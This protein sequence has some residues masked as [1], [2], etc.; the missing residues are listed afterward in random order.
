MIDRDDGGLEVVPG[1]HRMELFRPEEAD[2]E[3]SFAREYVPPPPGPTAVPVDMAP[4]DIGHHAGRSTRGI[5]GYYRTLS[6]S[7]GSVPLRESEGAAP[8][9]T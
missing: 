3:L 4:G 8:C 1:T 2:E 5:G 6:M 7:G 9:G